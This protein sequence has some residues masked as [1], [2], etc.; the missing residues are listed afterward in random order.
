MCLILYTHIMPIIIQVLWPEKWIEENADDQSLP[1]FLYSVDGVHCRMN[2]AIH[3]TLAKDTKAFSFKF[4]KA[5][6]AY[7]L[8]ISLYSSDLIWMN[9]P[10]K[11]STHDK[12]IFVGEDG[13]K[14]KTPTGKKGIADNGYKGLPDILSTPNSHDPRK[15]RRFKVRLPTIVSITDCELEE[16]LTPRF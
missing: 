6:A 3:A 11:A 5:G 12:T 10:F 7:E 15:L 14:D 9:G 8:G 16:P 2:E 4:K 1:T 13:L